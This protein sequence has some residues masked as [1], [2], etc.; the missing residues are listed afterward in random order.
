MNNRVIIVCVIIV[1][2]VIYLLCYNRKKEKFVDTPTTSTPVV[3][4][5]DVTSMDDKTAIN[6]LAQIAKSLMTD[7]LT[8]PGDVN[9]MGKFNYLPTGVIVA[10]NGKDVPKGWALCDGQNN[11]PDLRGR[12]ILGS[13]KGEKLTERISGQKDGEETHRLTVDEM[14][15]H[16]HANPNAP[17]DIRY[18]GF[19]GTADGGSAVGFNKESLGVNINRLII[20]AG[21]DN[22]H[23]NMPPYYVLAWIMKL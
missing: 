20:P 18:G 9:V 21:G 3:S 23:N 15:K 13:G 6:T 5:K 19:W 7:G 10:W 2:I 8:V 22:S 4:L 14:P 16:E 17:N 11:T 1:A 12:F